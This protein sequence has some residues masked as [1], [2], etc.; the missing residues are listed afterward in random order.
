MSQGSHLCAGYLC[1]T[2]AEYA[3]AMTEVRDAQASTSESNEHT[4]CLQA[5]AL[6][7]MGR[8]VD[9]SRRH[10]HRRQTSV[11]VTQVL[12]M[13]DGVRRQIAG[14]A[15]QASGRFSDAAFKAA[16]LDALA[17]AMPSLQ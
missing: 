5:P 16:F 17:P 15:R 1:S 14:A 13:D 3:E 9:G 4:D 7:H 6:W 12:A 8:A 11:Y 2:E 10:E